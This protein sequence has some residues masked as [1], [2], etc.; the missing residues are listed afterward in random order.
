MRGLKSRILGFLDDAV[1]YV[2]KNMYYIEQA[3]QS[4]ERFFKIL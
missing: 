3:T 1:S 4:L 2:E